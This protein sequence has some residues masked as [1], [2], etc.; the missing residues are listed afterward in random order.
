MYELG[1]SGVHEGYGDRE[2]ALEWLRTAAV[3]GHEGA[4]EELQRL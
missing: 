3:K 2:E 4:R 1:M